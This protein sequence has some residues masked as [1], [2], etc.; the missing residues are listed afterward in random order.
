MP[1]ELRDI[2]KG[3]AFE[4]LADIQAVCCKS[5]LSLEE[6]LDERR[7]TVRPS[8]GLQG[9]EDSRRTSF[10]ASRTYQDR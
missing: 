3:L 8:G 6:R 7:R 10:R 4:Q 2:A 1:S 5:R 9:G